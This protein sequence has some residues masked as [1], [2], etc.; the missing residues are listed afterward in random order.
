MSQYTPPE[1]PGYK[2][3]HTLGEGGM[4][5]V[6][7]ATQ[8]SLDRKVAIKILRTV[9]DDDP[10]RTERR[11]LR[12]G[13][14]L[15][16]ITHRNV[17]GIYDIAKIGDVAYIAME[18]LDG[19]TL[20]DRMRTGISVGESIAVVVQV[21]SAL[22]EAHNQ[23]IVHR[24]LKP[25][26]VMMRGGKIPVITDFGIARELTSHQTKITVENMIVGTPV[27]MSPEQV[28]GGEIDGR[29][30]VY[31]LGILFFELLTGNPPFKGDNPIQLCMQHLTAPVPELPD[32]LQELQPLMAKL[33][34][35][36]REDRFASMTD[37][38][39]ALRD[40]FVQSPSLRTKAELAPNQ[41]WTEQL[42]QMGFSF[43]TMRDAE[44]NQRLRSEQSQAQAQVGAK[45]ASSARPATVA[46]AAPPRSEPTPF[47]PAPEKKSAVKTWLI[48]AVLALL[49]ALGAGTYYFSSLRGPS[50]TDQIA[51]KGLIR[52]FETHMEKQEYFEPAISNAS[53]VLLDMRDIDRRSTALAARVTQLAKAINE[54]ASELATSGDIDGAQKLLEQAL[55]SEL[56]DDSA[57]AGA[58]QSV[59]KARARI[60]DADAIRQ[61]VQ[62][63]E[64]KLSEAG[65][66]LEVSAEFIALRAKLEASDATLVKLEQLAEAKFAARTEAALANSQLEQAQ[67]LLVNWRTAVPNSSIRSKFAGDLA[68]VRDRQGFAERVA[69]IRAQLQK[70]TLAPGDLGAIAEGIRS[71][72]ERKSDAPEIQQ[73]TQDLSRRLESLVQAALSAKNL[74]QADALVKALGTGFEANTA[75][76]S[77][78]IARARE[79]LRI[80]QLS[81]TLIIDAQ[82][83]STVLRI[84][85]SDGKA[86][87]LPKP[88]T[89][90]LQI[91]LLED[92][93]RIEVQAATG[94]R[95]QFTGQVRRATMTVANTAFADA[96]KQFLQEA[97]F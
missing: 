16:K 5:T 7:L 58:Q 65:S 14:T 8:I 86:A 4:A 66:T 39:H 2:L 22:Q 44:L 84:I 23:G 12:E 56:F 87:V 53:K 9:N 47:A 71:L 25:A 59:S 20:V 78:N 85:G 31:S 6:Y 55:A 67:L 81:G 72:A 90:P 27:Y 91:T 45:A 62:Q 37:F 17:C 26:N 83:V 3:L 95:R 11:F 68:K 69:E 57:L 93:Y 43:D 1:I 97:G 33:L 79:A 51:I 34:A 49:L 76:L 35:K 96:S 50:K 15:A 61:L 41:A 77:Q 28:S 38:T 82:P 60:E 48:P 46:T 32:S 63:I 18:F 75:V 89:T 24:D 88:S 92:T 36:K 13:R 52:E 19:G 74:D 54:K 29:S 42:R 10:E 80:E 94:Q 21:A 64:T 70:T 73:L 40:V 30:D